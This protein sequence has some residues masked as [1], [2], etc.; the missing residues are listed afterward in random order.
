MPRTR[1]AVQTGFDIGELRAIQTEWNDLVPQARARGIPRVRH[2][3]QFPCNVTHGRNRLNWLR[4]QLQ[5]HTS[6]LGLTFGFEIEFMLPD[7]P[8]QNRY[9]TDEL[10]RKLM[11]K[12][13]A[14]G[15]EA[16]V[17]SLNHNT[18]TWYKLTTD[19]SLN[20]Y[21]RGCE[22]VSPILSGEEGFQSL[23]T[24]A[25]AVTEH[26]GVANN[27]TINGRCGLHVH[28][29][30]RD[31]DTAFF[32]RLSN[33]YGTYEQVIDTFMAPSRRGDVMA[34]PSGVPLR[35][36]RPYTGANAHTALAQPYK[37]RKVNFA[38]VALRRTIEFRHH[39]GTTDPVKIENW[40]RL[41]LHMV[42]AAS[43][44]NL[45]LGPATFDGFMDTIGATA[46]ERA[47]YADRVR[48]F[49]TRAARTARRNN[50]PVAAPVAA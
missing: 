22:V 15:I 28:V 46:S 11:N 44:P 25:K 16:R 40:V 31:R 45:Q 7:E 30:V 23:R 17:E 27:R 8:R 12:L 13:N 6:T 20:D 19:G 4:S 49:E 9:D 33:L 18:R 24:V 1:L 41:C 47:Y 10:R 42:D 3:T 14:L 5:S 34:T 36:V 21:A 35:S 2:W 48:E 32:D 39:Q 50:Q 37:Y 29:G 38:N 26:T 43:N